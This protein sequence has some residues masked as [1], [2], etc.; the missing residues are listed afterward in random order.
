MMGTIG[1][2]AVHAH[3]LMQEPLLSLRVPLCH[4]APRLA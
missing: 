3:P 1:S 2:G 4:D